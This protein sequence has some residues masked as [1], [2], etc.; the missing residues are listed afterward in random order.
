V[1]LPAGFADDHFI[2][3]ENI[4]VFRRQKTGMVQKSGELD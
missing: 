3:G 4:L 2:T 1:R